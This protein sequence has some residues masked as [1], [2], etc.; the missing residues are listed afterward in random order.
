MGVFLF[1]TAIV[2]TIGTFII[3]AVL[4]DYEK[5]FKSQQH[6]GWLLALNT[7]G[8]C[9]ISAILFWIA[10]I[11]YGRFKQNIEAEKEEAEVKASQ[12]N[13][14][15]VQSLQH[16]GVVR[17]KRHTNDAFTFVSTREFRVVREQSSS[18]QPVKKRP[19][20]A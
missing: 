13:F 11:H 2:G 17:P 3:G 16:Y 19:I 12:F 1:A 4:G 10:S 14:S 5:E 7:A 15:D 18:L 6:K 9:L 8:P 20:I